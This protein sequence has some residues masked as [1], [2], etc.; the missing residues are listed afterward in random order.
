M[1]LISGVLANL[2]AGAKLRRNIRANAAVSQVPISK[3]VKLV[4][5]GLRMRISKVVI[6][7]IDKPKPRLENKMT[8]P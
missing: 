1:I 7:P 5:R 8:I 4:T 3:I 2:S 6:V